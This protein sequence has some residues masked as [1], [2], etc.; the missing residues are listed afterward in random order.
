MLLLVRH[1]LG[2]F[3]LASRHV[4]LVVCEVANDEL[5]LARVQLELIDDLPEQRDVPQPEVRVLRDE[6]RRAR[7]DHVGELLVAGSP[8]VENGSE[9]GKTMSVAVTDGGR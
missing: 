5:L 6:L 4:F 3:V 2:D 9:K 7:N 1:Q 8:I